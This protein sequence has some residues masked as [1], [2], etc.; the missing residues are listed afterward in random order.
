MNTALLWRGLSVF[1]VGVFLVT[2]FKTF[3][4]TSATS[5][6]WVDAHVRHQGFYGVLLYVGAVAVLTGVGVPRQLCSVLGGYVFGA[7]MGALWATVGTAIACT[8]CFCYA[9]FLGQAWIE[10]RFG[11]KMTRFNAFLRQSPFILTLMVRIV[12]LGSNFL[13]NFFAGVSAIPALPFLCGSFVGFSIQNII[14]ALLGSGLQADTGWHAA[15]S[16]ALYVAS[17]G[18]A[19]AVYRR[20]MRFRKK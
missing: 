8:A 18:L 6:A 16:G 19:W 11:H 12:P 4:L 17:L 10:R 13:T 2:V 7:W 1:C 5:E 14:F 15:V 20:Y 9:R 3:G